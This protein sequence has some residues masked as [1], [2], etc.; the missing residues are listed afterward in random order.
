LLSTEV[1]ADLAQMQALRSALDELGYAPSVEF[2]QFQKQTPRGPVKVDL[3]TGPITPAER[4]DDLRVKLPRVRPLGSVELHAYLTPEAIAADEGALMLP[5]EGSG[6][7]GESVEVRLPGPLTVILMK[8][9]AFRDRL[10]D[11]RKDLA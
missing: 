4:I 3:L 9:H 11:P 1:V 2:M 7:S 5:V 6:P 8:L 10:D